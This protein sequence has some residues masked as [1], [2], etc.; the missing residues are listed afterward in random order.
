MSFVSLAKTTEVGPGIIIIPVEQELFTLINEKRESN[1]LT[2]L[3]WDGEL[4]KVAATRA[5]EIAVSY[6]HT[7]P[8]G[9]A[10]Q[11]AYK[12]ANLYFSCAGENLAEGLAEAEEVFS[13][14]N[15]TKASKGN[16]LRSEFTHAAI[17]YYDRPNVDGTVT[18]CW[19]IELMKPKPAPVN[20]ETENSEAPAASAAV[21]AAPVSESPA[22]AQASAG[23]IPDTDVVN[24]H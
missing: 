13:K 4:A 20:T 21:S 14:W 6:G 24:G 15:S 17:A 23:D 10:P 11:T 16:L 22:G 8:N 18:R 19:V 9:S 7:R 5:S 1:N 3:I 12:E 2:P